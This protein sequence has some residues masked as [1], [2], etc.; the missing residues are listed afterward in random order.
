MPSIGD[1][2]KI[3][4]IEGNKGYNHLIWAEA[5]AYIKRLEKRVTLLEAEIILLRTQTANSVGG[6]N[7]EGILEKDLVA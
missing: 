3:K 4:R 2:S 7:I 1:L 6:E 5:R